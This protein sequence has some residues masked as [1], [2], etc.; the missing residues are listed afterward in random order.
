MAAIAEL[1]RLP[2][3][4]E[5][6]GESAVAE[7]FGSLKRAFALILR[8]TGPAEWDAIRQS[9]TEDLLVYLALARF[10][11]RPP[12][13]QLPRTLQHDMRAFFGT[14]T[15]ACRRADELLFRAGNS[16]AIDEACERSPVGKLLPDDLYVHRSALDTLE[17]LLRV[18]EGCG[19][20]Y[21]GEVEGANV[22][23]IHR[24]SG[25]LSYLVY[26]EFEDDPHPAL[27]RSIRVNLRMRQIDCNDYA[28]SANPPVLHRK[29]SFLTPDH[30]LH[31][32]F[33]RL[34]AQEE[35]NGLLD[36]PSGIGTREGWSK[37]LGE[38]GYS[39]KGHRLVRSNGQRNGAS[40]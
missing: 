13:G 33:A 34:T 2:E 1:G 11:K 22:I 28:Q 14:Y 39:L 31:A 38:R 25:K 9:R 36:N 35:R 12:L 6:S 21:L 4:D 7:E 40:F 20:A 27:L 8:V 3:D 17:P 19:R 10:R 16:A 37:R 29:D 18:Y 23:K 24:R 5:F 26:P 15:K 32:K 30:P